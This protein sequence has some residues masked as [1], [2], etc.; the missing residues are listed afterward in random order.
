MFMTPSAALT[1]NAAE[2]VLRGAVFSERCRLLNRDFS[3]AFHRPVR[4]RAHVSGA[5]ADNSPDSDKELKRDGCKV[6]IFQRRSLVLAP[7]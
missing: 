2:E 3:F 6:L 4:H 1:E 5:G 7:H